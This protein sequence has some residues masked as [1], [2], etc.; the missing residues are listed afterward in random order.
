MA[1]RNLTRKYKQLR[2]GFN[3]RRRPR[4][5]GGAVGSVDTTNELFHTLPPH[6]VESVEEIN[7]I[8]KQIQ[9]KINRLHEAHK[10]RLLVRFDDTESAQDREIDT[11]TK[12][13]T[14]KFREAERKLTQRIANAQVLDAGAGDAV[15][16]KNIQRQLA[17]QLQTLSMSF[18][19]SQKEYMTRLKSQKGG[20]DLDGL[21]GADPE[22]PLAEVGGFTDEQAVLLEIAETNVQERDQEIQKI[23]TSISELA[24]IFKELSVLVIDQGTIL[25]R[26]DY[27]MTLVEEQTS[28]GLKQ[29]EKTESYNKST[30]PLKCI[31]VLVVLIIL[32]TI[33]LIIKH[34]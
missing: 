2:E 3:Q 28:K 21:L 31:T 26:I 18:R 1:T 16:R 24:T 13:I 6:W 34:S 7:D 9:Q 19:K 20:G 23:A 10:K 22:Q 5:L 25:D 12:Q 4:V 29:L 14:E 17:Q 11:L 32:F 8:T 30:R 33:I 15:V 27:N